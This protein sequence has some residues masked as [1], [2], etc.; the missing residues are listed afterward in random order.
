[1]L[2]T[3]T[4]TKRVLPRD[5]ELRSQLEPSSSVSPSAQPLQHYERI[6]D[7]GVRERLLQQHRG[8]GWQEW[9]LHSNPSRLQ[10]ELP[11]MVDNFLHRHS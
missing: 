2:S 10:A 5:I 11:K 3:S 6:D 1:M 4:E 9:K 8:V 7:L